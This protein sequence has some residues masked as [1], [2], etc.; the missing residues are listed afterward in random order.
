MYDI[1]KLNSKL[2]AELKEIAK[3]LKIPKYDKL[4]KQDLIYTILD[5]QAINPT[6]D[7][8]KKEKKEEQRAKNQRKRIVVISDVKAVA[9]KRQS[10]E[11]LLRR[12]ALKSRKLKPRLRLHHQN[13]KQNLLRNKLIKLLRV[14]KKHLQHNH[15]KERELQS[16]RLRTKQ[17]NQQFKVRNLK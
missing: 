10:Q 4:N 3:N 17:K 14:Q 16:Q 15:G 1:L 12:K 9:E 13:Q 11:K 6:P 7:I 2:V 5:H 8:L